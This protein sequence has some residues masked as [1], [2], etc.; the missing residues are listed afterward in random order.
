M[1]QQICCADDEEHPRGAQTM[2]VPC[3]DHSITRDTLA[4]AIQN[5]EKMDVVG[6]VE[7]M[8]ETL[9]LFDA[10]LTLAPMRPSNYSNWASRKQHY[11]PQ[12]VK[13]S[14]Q[15]RAHLATLCSLDMELYEHA[16]KIFD[17]QL[18]KIQNKYI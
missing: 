17:K 6:I 16:L 4:C 8:S 12:Q 1:T 13:L 11:S 10:L 5:L 7:R 3:A 14:S 15:Q 9:I 2:L 18:R